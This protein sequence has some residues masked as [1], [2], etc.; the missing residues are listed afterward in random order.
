M[1]IMKNF[2]FTSKKII[3]FVVLTGYIMES[4]NIMAPKADAIIPSGVFGKPSVCG[5]FNFIDMKLIPLTQGQFAQVDDWNYDWLN[6]WKWCARKKRGTYYAVR[7]TSRSLGPDKI[8]QMHRVI[9]NTPNN[10]LCDHRDHNGLNNQ[11][12]NLRNCTIA[13]NQRNR[14]SHSKSGY[15]GVYRSKY[16][17]SRDKYCIWGQIEVDGI[18]YYLGVSKTE[19]QAAKRYDAAAQ[20]FF[21]EFANLN[22]K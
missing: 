15:L 17:L 5:A 12:N 4:K 1:I 19:E 2:F 16:S 7:R 11:E 8:I 10:L 6:Q 13:E 21:G 9:K 14:I 22:F 20:Y 18:R 3:I